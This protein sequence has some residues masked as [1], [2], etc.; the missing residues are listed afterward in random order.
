MAGTTAFVYDPAEIEAMK[1]S[2]MSI[3]NSLEQNLANAQAEL[4]A[5]KDALGALQNATD[6]TYTG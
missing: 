4:Q 2:L 3:Y 6:E 1:S 5:A